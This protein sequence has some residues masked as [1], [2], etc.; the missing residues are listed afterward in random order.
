MVAISSQPA[1]DWQDMLRRAEVSDVY[2][3]RMLVEVQGSAV[4]RAAAD[5]CGRGRPTQGAGRSSDRG[6]G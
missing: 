5:R 2:E 3:V 6:G 4:G 1:Q